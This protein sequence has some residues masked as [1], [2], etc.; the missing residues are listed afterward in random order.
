MRSSIPKVMG[1]LMIIFASL[2]LLFGLIGL[3]GNKVPPELKDVDAFKTF[4]TV[5]MIFGVVGLGVS[6]IH[7]LAGVSAVRYKTGAPKLALMYGLVN[8]VWNLANAIAVMAWLKPA[9]VKA[10]E[11]QG[12]SHGIG[13]DI[14][15][16]VGVMVIVTTVIGLIWPTLV[17]FLMSRPAAKAACTN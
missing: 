14:G 16:I 15:A 2:G 12:G 1:I 9:L 10:M 4:G 17:L 8:I 6:V 7:L 3:G 11:E 13:F 5:T